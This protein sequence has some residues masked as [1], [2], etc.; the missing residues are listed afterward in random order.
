[1][2]SHMPKQPT[3]EEW[4]PVS[5]SNLHHVSPVIISGEGNQC[6]YRAV[7]RALAIGLEDVVQLVQQSIE[8]IVDASILSRHVFLAL[9]PSASGDDIRMA[10]DEYLSSLNFKTMQWGGSR[11]MYLVSYACKGNL[12]F[13]AID[14]SG[15]PVKRYAAEQLDPTQAVREIT[16]HHC[17][18]AP[19]ESFNNHYNAFDYVFEDGSVHS[20]WP[21]CKGETKE[22]REQREQ[23]LFRAVGSHSQDHRSVMV[24]LSMETEAAEA[25]VQAATPP[26]RVLPVFPPRKEDIAE[27]RMG[28]DSRATI[29]NPGD[30]LCTVIASKELIKRKKVASGGFAVVFRFDV[31]WQTASTTW[32]NAG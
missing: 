26:R 21:Y 28:D 20:V 2:E 6:W 18:Y 32:T 24:D 25:D 10:K 30:P 3:T 22:Q 8:E 19:G 4:K 11:E 16:L 14:N 29:H 5:L 31:T 27:I 7:A 9:L 23:L 13:L 1:M 17:A 15:L 12:R